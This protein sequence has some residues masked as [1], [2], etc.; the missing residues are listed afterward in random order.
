M[1]ATDEHV[2]F[3][4]CKA[5]NDMS[6]E[7]TKAKLEIA[8]GGATLV[9]ESNDEAEETVVTTKAKVGKKKTQKKV[10]KKSSTGKTAKQ[11]IITKREEISSQ[12]I[13]DISTVQVTK[14]SHVTEEEDIE[15][16][17]ETE[18]I[19]VKVYKEAY[20]AEEIEN[21]KIAEEVNS[22]LETIQA[23]QFGSGEQPLR[24]LATVGHLLA[25]GVEIC[26]IMK[27]YNADFFP[28]LKMPESQSAMVQLVERQGYETLITEILNSV[29]SIED[30]NLLASTVGFRAFMRLVE[31]THN[32]VEDI[33]TNFRCEDFVSQEWKHRESEFVEMAEG[34]YTRLRAE[35][36]TTIG[37]SKANLM[38]LIEF[39]ILPF[40]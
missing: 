16:I 28:A 3:Y 31:E 10:S 9:A 21:F 24:E 30:E 11:Q 5:M 15:I 20:S 8:V 38:F 18:E 39:A 19:R 26:E 14:K 7:T 22:I 33:M 36:T 4:T 1:K 27:L 13:S 17:E 34:R 12:H 40:G 23:H 25:K 32:S 29:E 35:K 2:G 6:E 37:N